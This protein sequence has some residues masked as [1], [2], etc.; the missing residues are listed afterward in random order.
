MFCAACISMCLSWLANFNALCVCS[1]LLDEGVTATSMHLNATIWRFK[2]QNLLYQ[3]LLP[4]TLLYFL[5]F[6]KA[7]LLYYY[8]IKTGIMD[9]KL[10]VVPRCNARFRDIDNSYFHDGHFNAMTANA[11]VGPPT[12]PAPMQQIF[13]IFPFLTYPQWC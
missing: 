4:A 9:R 10:I 2:E 5:F 3:Q 6:N 12:C 11:I 7:T 13:T 1:L 8:I